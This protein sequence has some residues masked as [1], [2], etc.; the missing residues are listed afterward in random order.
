MKHTTKRILSLVLVLCTMLTMFTSVLTGCKKDEI[1]PPVDE[2]EDIQTNTDKTD[3]KDDESDKKDE[4]DD[5][6][7]GDLWIENIWGSE[8]K[9]PTN[10]PI[11]KPSLNGGSNGNSNGN[12]NGGSSDNNDA[13]VTVYRK[14]TFAYPDTMSAEDKK[15]TKLPSEQLVDSGELVYSMPLPVREGYVF[16]G[17]YY[18]SDLAILAGTEDVISKNITLYP[19]MVEST[20]VEEGEGSLNYVSALDVDISHEITVKA[21]S[22][23]AV[24]DSLVLTSVSDGN[25]AV[26]FSVTDNGDGTYTVLPSGGLKAGKTY[27][28]SAIDREKGVNADGVVPADDEYVL[29]IHDGEVQK[30]E[31]RFYNIFTERKEESNLKI[32]DE[33]KFVDLD[34]VSGFDMEQATGLYTVSLSETGNV[35]M[36][37]N[38]ASG[39]FTY[40]GSD[41]A[42]GD[43]IA[44]HNGTI[45]KE[46]NTITDGDVAYI[47]ITDKK[48]TQYYYK[49]ADAADVVFLPDVLPVP[50]HAD[51]DENENT[52][53]VDNDVLDFTYFE[54]QEVLNENTKV[55][56]GDF[57]ALYEGVLG[58]TETADYFEI[59]E[60]SKGS[61]N[62]VLTVA[63]VTIEELKNAL[64]TYET[65]GVDMNLPE[66]E[67]EALEEKIIEQ[68]EESG[69]AEKSAQYI[70]QNKLGTDEEIVWGK[71]YH[72]SAN[73]M[74]LFG[75]DVEAG[76][77]SYMVRLDPPDIRAEVTTKLKKVTELKKGTGLRV[78]FGVTIPVGIEVVE[79]GHR[80]IESFYLD[81]YVTFEQEVK[82]N[83]R[84]SADVQW[85]NRAYIIWWIDEVVVNAGFDMGVYTGVGAVASV[86]TE[87]YHQKSYF[88]NELV[89]KKDGTFSSASN[90]ATK[91]NNMLKD[92]NVSFFDVDAENSLINEYSKMLEREIDYVDI[93][94]LRLY[95][96]K[97]YV[98]PKTHIVNYV[99][100]VELVFGAKLNI[101]MGVSFEALNVKQYNFTLRMFDATG[102][103]SVVDK[104]TPYTNFN[105]F[106]MGN[107]G[108][109]AGIRV[110]FSIGLISVKLDN[111]G[112]MIEVGVYLDLYGFFYFHYDWNGKTNKHNVQSG[113]ALY[114]AIG[115][116]IDLDLFGGVLLD[117]ASFRVHLY[118]G[119]LELWNSGNAENIVSVVKPN[120]KQTVYNSKIFDV[121]PQFL[122]M[123]KMNVLTG[124][125]YD[126]DK[127]L[128]DFDVSLTNPK[129]SYDKKTGKISVNPDVSDIT[130]KTQV[131]FTYTGKTASFTKEPLTV[132]LDLTW[133][134]TEPTVQVEYYEPF[135]ITYRNGVSVNC[136]DRA[137]T[138]WYVEGSKLPALADYND[139]KAGYDFHG[140][141]IVCDA[142]PEYNGKMLH[143]VNCL[144]GVEMPSTPIGLK[145]IYTTRTDTPYTVTHLIPSIE[146]P[147]VYEV[148][149]EEKKI[150]TTSDNINFE[151]V[152]Y[153]KGIS[154]DFEKFPIY[155]SMKLSDGRIYNTYGE[156]I[157]GD[158]STNLYI[159]YTR[160]SY[161]VTIDSNNP[162]YVYFGNDDKAVTKLLKFGETIEV[163][164]Y[165]ETEIPGY[166]FKGWSLT[167][168]G[169]SGLIELPET[170]PALS[171]KS[172]TYYAIWEAEDVEFNVEYFVQ[173]PDGTFGVT[174][175]L[176]ETHTAPVGSSIRYGILAP[177]DETVFGSAWYSTYIADIVREDGTI[178]D[179]EKTHIDAVEPITIS[180]YFKRNYKQVWWNNTELDY[181][182]EGQEITMPSES[183]NDEFKKEGY[184][185]IGWTSNGYGDTKVYSVGE[186]YVMGKVPLYFKPV[187]EAKN[188]TPYVVNHIR[189]DIDGSFTSSYCE[190]ETENLTGTTDSKVSP[191]VKS[192]EGFTSPSKY[193]V[194]ISADGSTVV[195]YHYYRNEHNVKIETDGGTLRGRY[196]SSY[197]YGVPFYVFE[198]TS[199]YS[200]TKTGY[201]L[202]GFYLKGDETK[203]LIATDYY[204][205]GDEI[206]SDED[207]VFVALWEAKPYSYKTE[208]YLQQLDGTYVLT[209]TETGKAPYDSTVKA[210]EITFT[211]FTVDKN[212]NGTVSSG[213]VTSDDALTLKLYYTRN[214]YDAKWMSYDG[215]TVLATTK[216]KFGDTIKAPATFNQDNTRPGY[217]LTGWLDVEY[218]KMSA[219]GATLYAKT[220][221]IW[222]AASYTIAFN[223]NGATSGSM[224]SL[225]LTYGQSKTLTA[226][227][228]KKTGY[229]FNGWNTKADG[230]GVKY[231]DQESVL[232]L[233]TS[234]TVTLYAQWTAG[235]STAYKVEHY[236][237]DLAGKFVVDSSKTQSFTGVTNSTV[238]A[239]S[240]T[241]DG[242]TFDS[243]NALN[244]KSATVNANGN[245]VLKLYY[246]RNSYDLVF[247]FNNSTIKTMVDIK[248][249]DEE[250]GKEYVAGQEVGNF[251]F[252][253]VTVSVKHGQTISDAVKNVEIPEAAGYTFE[254]WT[255][256]N[257][258]YNE[259]VTMPVGGLTLFANWKPIEIT[260]TFHTGGNYSG[261]SG[262]TGTTTTKTYNYGDEISL[263]ELDFAYENHVIVGWIFNDCSGGPGQYPIHCEWPL[264]LVYGRY[265]EGWG[266]FD[267]DKTSLEMSPF[268]SSS[269]TEITFNGNGG[270]G[271][272]EKQLIDRNAGGMPIFKNKFVRD[273]YEF[274]G[275]NT[276]QDGSG[277][278]YDI[279]GSYYPADVYGKSEV[280]LY[281]QWKEN[282]AN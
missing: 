231:S 73:Q 149:K 124:D 224:Q 165:A 49:S 11:N 115:L 207:I 95:H 183:D 269:Y 260:I 193:T 23:K 90:I 35:A 247:D 261:Y 198:D 272:M 216:V 39:S 226:N 51:K 154:L 102:S 52:L 16:A 147:S 217:A 221:G 13:D 273:G 65:N 17:W 264:Q 204:I 134:K 237:E 145:P 148:Y 199:S 75:M 164:D 19:K 120:V 47:E 91:L 82:F 219:D 14:V 243:N 245:T 41:I 117:L 67:V 87:K 48:G 202:K 29:F 27:Q 275:W 50:K 135:V 68:A 213:K 22:E 84:F 282:S 21:K 86:Y 38:S 53:T 143:D 153:E 80:V 137:R 161:S 33:V 54:N 98:D 158:G 64:S 99:I 155:H 101:T 12:S 125:T 206:Y 72:L 157:K 113:G 44:L 246:T 123:R 144:E 197:K 211:G 159:Y 43:V 239:S 270:T 173:K 212:I 150:G 28:L 256:E 251:S 156:Y 265:E 3:E 278:M 220:S 89:E 146:D 1:V 242:F 103:A 114:A 116:Y 266:F 18:D 34:K 171:E 92:G 94:A 188:D 88:W 61:E 222:T 77:L 175:D 267:E 71:K 31:I 110:T 24:N 97:G 174:P 85:D 140:W 9:K 8:D 151:Q 109:R 168:D 244:V 105:F 26:P 25:S 172:I 106:I 162:D 133:K 238:N 60:V 167:K 141:Q 57:I 107:L 62:T 2:T 214:T 225:S 180:A 59:T 42:V 189:E 262:V 205:S 55:N 209:Q 201:V 56:I 66:S 176:T 268:W 194:T 138:K 179:Y 271:S 74:Q 132:I 119:E 93:L 58:E 76:N 36:R 185:L 277:E 7:D 37:N 169:S 166:T 32:D 254:N 181:C 136:P 200:L 253:S 5:I 210:D 112:A 30:K 170:V 281:A 196:T 6:S 46:E 234:G 223:G 15:M 184:T 258:S 279:D 250:T 230:T 235:N 129:F 248:E 121:N 252:P 182:Y 255:L 100:D 69:F 127:D 203:T 45:N 280:I 81:L 208:Y 79:N 218:G 108:L 191:E 142:L 83:T 274:I 20:A 139:V 104:Q 128:D 263:P 177:E 186:K 4:K 118:E 10:S 228:F 111:L 163:P 190:K 233:A 96:H 241:V 276:E 160:D 257:A 152:I 40:A 240:I 259:S 130:L 78:A 249:I 195:N 232:N 122:K 178:V 126:V 70:L 192:Y 131:R 63:P 215:S 236:F 227:A 229:V 187:Y